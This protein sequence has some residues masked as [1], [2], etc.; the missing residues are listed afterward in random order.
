M[1]EN[2]ALIG[3]LNMDD[4]FEVWNAVSRTSNEF[5]VV[6]KQISSMGVEGNSKRCRVF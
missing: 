2:V 3:S 1:G 4:G 5:G 6:S